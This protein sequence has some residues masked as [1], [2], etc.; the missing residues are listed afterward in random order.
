MQ[1]RSWA[2]ASFAVFLTVILTSC[3]QGTECERCISTLFSGFTYVGSYPTSAK[4]EIYSMQPQSFP[5]SFEVGRTYI[6]E[7]NSPVTTED[8]AITIL[9]SRL[10]KCGATVIEAPHSPNNLAPVSLGGPAWEIR[11]TLKEC[12]GR[13]A[14][15]LNPTLLDSRRGWRDGSLDDYMLELSSL[16]CFRDLQWYT[17]LRC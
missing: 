13:I 14:N 12:R 16:H 8:T 11:F 3:G 9:P 10:R 4:A 17:S 5:H 15:R 2:M 7:P 6:F 1:R